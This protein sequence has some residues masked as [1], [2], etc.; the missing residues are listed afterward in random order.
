MK[1]LLRRLGGLA[2]A[3]LGAAAFS[4]A[5]SAPAAAA[6]VT[7]KLHHFLP[8]QANVPKLALGVWADRIKE[9]SKGRLEVQIYPAMQLGGRP[10]ELM[11]QIIDGAVDIAW[12]VIGYTPGRF[13]RTEVFELPFMMTADPV[14]T[15]RAFW[16]LY[17]SEMRDTE[18]KSLKPLAVW[19]H[20]PG[21]IHS[22][23]PVA[24]LADLKGV[25]I[26]GGSRVINQLLTHLGA[27]P[28]GMPVPAVSE[29]LSKGVISATTIPWEVT[30]A[31]KV[32]EL[33]HNHT[34]F[35]GKA[36]YTLT[37]V[38]GMNRASY[39]NLPAD[40]KKVIDENSGAELSA[41]I[42]KV[43]WEADGPAREK[44]VKMGNNIIQLSPKQVQ[45]WEEASK[46]VYQ[47]WSDTVK[48]QGIDGDALIAK[49]RALIVKHS[50]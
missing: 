21:L 1:S 29:G 49:A 50:K 34:E 18:F 47:A 26:R 25:K 44:A 30:S 48:K 19:V 5:V 23:Q 38:L 16:E 22:A 12:T 4:L 35:P 37:F 28:V 6:E 40:L 31:L 2:V 14:S 45:E 10:P 46:P 15:S 36:L 33:V 42:A 39:D 11:D 8:P 17:E 43:Q 13:P 7:L 9:A 27:T 20:G 32:P 41:F 24:S 3:G